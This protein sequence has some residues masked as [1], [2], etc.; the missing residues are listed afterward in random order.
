MSDDRAAISALVLT[1]MGD[2]W[3]DSEEYSA[4][5]GV[6]ADLLLTS[7]WLAAEKAKLQAE[8]RERIA[9]AIETWV[10]EDMEKYGSPGPLGSAQHRA[11]LRRAAH[12]ARQGGSDD[13]R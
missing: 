9:V 12:I 11:G 3:S 13:D 1:A 6:V 10:A 7:D 2:A 8:E 5:P 4:L